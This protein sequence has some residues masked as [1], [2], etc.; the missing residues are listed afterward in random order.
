MN[1]PRGLKNCG[2]R[3]E[4][5]MHDL[6]QRLR[7]DLKKAILMFCCEQT[8]CVGWYFRYHVYNYDNLN[9]LKVMFTPAIKQQV[10]RASQAKWLLCCSKWN[11]LPSNIE[12]TWPRNAWKGPEPASLPSKTRS[13]RK[14]NV[15]ADETIRA[16]LEKFGMRLA[17]EFTQKNW[18]CV[19][20][21]SDSP[22]PR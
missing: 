3:A 2:F 15:I 11:G 4:G 8:L 6:D 12:G 1:W 7:R 19:Y 9:I 5:T 21:E 10:K 20:F 13:S 22:R 16:N 17:A 18:Q 14:L